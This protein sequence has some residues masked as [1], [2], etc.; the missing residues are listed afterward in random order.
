RHQHRA[1]HQQI[2]EP[3]LPLRQVGDRSLP[4]GSDDPGAFLRTHALRGDQ[5]IVQVG[6]DP[7]G[8]LCHR[9]LLRCRGETSWLVTRQA[10]VGGGKPPPYKTPHSLIASAGG[11]VSSAPSTVAAGVS[12]QTMMRS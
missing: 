3:T 10:G 8:F 7:D 11:A 4:V 2:Q 1:R 9:Y 12:W 6:E 5:A